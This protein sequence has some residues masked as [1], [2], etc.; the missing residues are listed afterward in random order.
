MSEIE[1][2]LNLGAW[3]QDGGATAYLA[4]GNDLVRSSERFEHDWQSLDTG[5]EGLRSDARS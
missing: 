4:L 1:S 3:M 2:P 5:S